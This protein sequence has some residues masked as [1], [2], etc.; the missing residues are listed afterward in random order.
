MGDE[1][2]GVKAEWLAT[3][4]ETDKR[5]WLVRKADRYTFCLFFGGLI[6]TLTA[7]SVWLGLWALD[8]AISAAV[9]LWGSHVEVE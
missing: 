3:D 6:L 2:T 9:D 4:T 1:E 5:P 8:G 7:G